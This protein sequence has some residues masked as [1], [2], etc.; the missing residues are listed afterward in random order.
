MTRNRARHRL[1]TELLRHP[2]G[3]KHYGYPLGKAAHIRPARVY[4]LLDEWMAAGWLTDGWDE[5]NLVYYRRRFYVVTDEG[6]TGLT[7][8]KAEP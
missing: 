3:S 2:P 1:A 6:V 4:R 7:H 8:L 5:E